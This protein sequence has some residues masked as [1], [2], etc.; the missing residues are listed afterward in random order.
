[1]KDQQRKNVKLL[2]I[3]AML[4]WV[5]SVAAITENNECVDQKRFA[6]T[7]KNGVFCSQ[8]SC[9]RRI[10]DGAG[11]KVGYWFEGA[12]R[13]RFWNNLN[14]EVSGSYFKHLGRDL[15]CSRYTEVKIPTFGLGIKYFFECDKFFDCCDSFWNR[16][17]PFIGCGLRVFFYDESNQDLFVNPCVKERVVGGMINAGVEIDVYK[18]LF[19]DLFVDYVGAKVKPCCSKKLCA[20]N[21]VLN[22]LCCPSSAHDLNIGG[23]VIGAAIGYKF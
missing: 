4:F 6:V 14:L 3:I 1:M 10:F 2:P 12:A 16:F 20:S 8:D 19:I 13:W 5:S 9:L 17:S 21:S 11:S 23:V 15:S 7:V 18:G 22:N